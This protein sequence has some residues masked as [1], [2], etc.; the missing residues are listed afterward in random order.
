MVLPSCQLSVYASSVN[1]EI[2]NIKISC[3][4]HF[5]REQALSLMSYERKCHHSSVRLWVKNSMPDV[6][7]HAV[8]PVTPPGVCVWALLVPNTS[9]NNAAKHSGAS[10]KR[11]RDPQA[12]L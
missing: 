9:S 2:S 4:K 10:I 6:G 11:L 5:W 1:K 12:V 3:L 7:K 8:L